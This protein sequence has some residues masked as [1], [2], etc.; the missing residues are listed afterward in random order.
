[1]SHGN[2]CLCGRAARQT[3]GCDR[4]S[5]WHETN[6][7]ARDGVRARDALPFAPFNTISA[8]LK[9]LPIADHHQTIYGWMLPLFLILI[10]LGKVLLGKP[11]GD[12]EPCMASALCSFSSGRV[13]ASL[14]FMVQVAA[15]LHDCSI[16]QRTV[17]KSQSKR[18]LANEAERDQRSLQASLPACAS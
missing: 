8:V 13:V 5:S 7:R 1:M 14:R 4:I 6:G 18:P 3:P 10:G 11:M 16:R 2:L 9:G 17:H 12:R 15:L